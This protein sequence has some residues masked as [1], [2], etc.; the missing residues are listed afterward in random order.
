MKKWIAMIMVLV[1]MLSLAACGGNESGKTNDT[2]KQEVSAETENVVSQEQVSDTQNPSFTGKITEDVL[3]SYPETPVAEFTY[4]MSSDYEGI[5]IQS[6]NGTNDIVVIPATIDGQPVVDIAEY[7]FANSST[8]RGVYIPDTVVEIGELFT[9]SA[10][11]EVVIAE[12]VQIIR[13]GCFVSCPALREV[14]LGNALVK[15]EVMAFSDCEKL[16][17][18]N[19]APTLVELTEDEK[20][21]LFFFCP[22][23]TIYGEAGSFIE[24]VASEKGIP[25]VAE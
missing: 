4:A 16:E 7:S 12:G 9:N 1:M 21:T 10:C 15:L 25:F 14:V 20:N 6:Y 24:T 2:N 23:L 8:V 13:T 17:K 19:I 5:L 3:R 22:N 18:I 11:I